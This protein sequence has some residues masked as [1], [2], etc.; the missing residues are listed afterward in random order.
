MSLL[1]SAI[2]YILITST[3]AYVLNANYLVYIFVRHEKMIPQTLRGSYER[4]LFFWQIYEKTIVSSPKA[5]ET[6]TNTITTTT[7][8]AF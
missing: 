8:T 5:P 4:I 3:P 7:L 2:I 6:L 1:N